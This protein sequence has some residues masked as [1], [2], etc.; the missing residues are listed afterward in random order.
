MRLISPNAAVALPKGT[1]R[2]AEAI[3]RATARSAAGSSRRM[4]PAILTKMSA[5]AKA[6]WACRLNTATII[7]S[8]LRSKP[9]AT[10]RGRASSLALTSAWTSTKKQRDPSTATKAHEPGCASPSARNKRE[11]SDTPLRPCSVI[12]KTPT[13]FVDPKRF[14]TARSTR[15]NRLRSPSNCSTVSTMC[16]STRGPAMAPSFVTWPTSTT[17]VPVSFARRRKRPA[18]S[19]TWLTL[20]GADVKSSV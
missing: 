6:I 16:S 11:G 2:S 19:R 12:S 14:F 5:E 1:P 4:P 18:A 8:R 17:A 15:K 3:A 13:S 20:P 10:R 7:A 9:V